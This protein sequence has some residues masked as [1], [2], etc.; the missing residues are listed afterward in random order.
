M[1]AVLPEAQLLIV[2]GVGHTVHLERP[3][4]WVEAV[5]EFICST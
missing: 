2:P 4:R 3:R 1:T 5:A